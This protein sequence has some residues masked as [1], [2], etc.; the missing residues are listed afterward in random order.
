M[1][2]RQ[3]AGVIWLVVGIVLA[4]ATVYLWDGWWWLLTMPAA[5]RTLVDAFFYL[6]AAWLGQSKTF[7]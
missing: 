2:Q 3:R 6:R 4:R 1:N 7:R 5:V